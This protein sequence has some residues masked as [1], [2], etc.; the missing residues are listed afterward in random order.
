MKTCTNTIFLFVRIRN[1]FEL[2]FGDCSCRWWRLPVR[3]CRSSKR[4]PSQEHKHSLSGGC[5]FQTAC[6]G[7]VRNLKILSLLP[8]AVIFPPTQG[9]KRQQGVGGTQAGR[10]GAREPTT[11]EN[12]HRCYKNPTRHPRHR[13]AG[14]NTAAA[15]GAFPTDSISLRFADSG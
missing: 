6:T 12:D 3:V 7:A 14:N 9:C 1:T 4:S 5:S 11:T 13:G 15:G 2:N 10:G 8:A